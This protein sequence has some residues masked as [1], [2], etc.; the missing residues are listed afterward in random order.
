MLLYR[1]YSWLT[2]LYSLE[3]P[4]LEKETI[5]A[6]VVH[7]EVLMSLFGILPAKAPDRPIIYRETE[8]WK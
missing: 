5:D 2:H 8:E 7:E 3:M 4:W 6:K 1:N